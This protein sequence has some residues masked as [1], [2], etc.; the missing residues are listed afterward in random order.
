MRPQTYYLRSFG[1]QMNEH[2]SERIA[3]LLEEMGVVATPSPEEADVLVYNTCSIREK[4]DTRLAGHL[5]TAAR[6]KKER[7]SRLVVVAGCLAQSRREE[8]FGDFPF[9]DVLV[10]P[11]SLHELPNLLEQRLTRGEAVGAFADTTTRWSADL[12]RTRV[13]GPSAWV[14][15]VAGCS[16]YCT[17]CIVPSVRG[18]EASRPAA[19]ILPEVERLAA[20]GVREITLLGQN[21][22]AYGM[23]AGFEGKE[24]FPDLL[25]L[26]G[27]IPGIERVRFMTSHPK[28]VSDA[29]IDVIATSKQVC[30]HVHLP[31]QS[32]SDRILA[33]MNRRYDRRG[34]VD[35][36]ARLRRA[37]PELALTTDLIVGFPGETEEDFQADPLARRGVP[38]RRGLHLH[39]LAAARYRGRGASRPPAGRRDRRAH[40]ETG[41]CCAA[42]R[43]RAQPGP[44]RADSRSDGGAA[45]PPRGRRGHGTDARTQ[46]GEFLV[47]RRT[48]RHGMGG[49]A[50][51]HLH[52][53]SRAAGRVSGAGSERG[54]GGE[55]AAQR[56]R[57]PEPAAP[58]AG[59]A[60]RAAIVIGVLGP[61]GVGKTPVAAA[62]ARSLGVRVISCDSM[63][64]YRGFPVLTNQPSPGEMRGVDHTL[65][66]FVDPVR[67]FS[68]AEYAAFARPLVATDADQKGAAVIAGG[69]GLYL[70]AALAPL[71]VAP[72]DAEVRARLEARATAEGADALHAELARL[73]PTGGRSRGP[74][75][76][77]PGG[78]RLGSAPRRGEGMVGPGRPV[79]P[80]LRPADPGGG[81]HA[82]PGRI[83]RAHRSPGR[84]DGRRGSR[85]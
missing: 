60:A 11:Q 45:K 6:L 56:A 39:L 72:S 51:S 19:D 71:A 32:G 36:V 69:T 2:D 12:P 70:R 76:R 52:E 21:V 23:E 5:G 4:A 29:L 83:G 10:G 61:T 17:Y 82:G 33:A 85:G 22:N 47:Q 20:S 7:P 57:A 49:V 58:A 16:N 46:A 13:N 8:F 62:L 66:G 18:P 55:P 79:E 44:H 74:E 48:G 15:I 34:Y 73:D 42:S 68:A 37:V 81:T 43:P 78:P 63:Q 75:E 64:V 28:D 41:G 3:G 35:L 25:R 30:E 84:Q 80:S 65:V 50:R 59:G 24:R 40:G 31:V 38:F 77:P 27:A 14:Q 9:V 54:G 53:L 26:T 1:C 67:G